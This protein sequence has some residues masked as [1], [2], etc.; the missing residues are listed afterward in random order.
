[1]KKL[2]P[3]V[4]ITAMAGLIILALLPG[5][6]ELVTNDNYYYDTLRIDGTIHEADTTCGICHNDKTDSITIAKRQ[7]EFSA[8][9]TGNLTDYDFLGENTAVCGPECHTK[10]GYVQY[11]ADLTTG[12]VYF[13]TEI[14]CFACHSPHENK[15]FSLR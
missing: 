13:P 9:S 3:L 12:T 11:L 4:V 7:W 8:H 5:C 2:F 10:E 15:N 6:D 1:M 14:G